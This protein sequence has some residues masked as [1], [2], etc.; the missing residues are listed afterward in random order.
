MTTT[1]ILGSIFL[2]ARTSS[3]PLMS[4]M[5]NSETTTAQCTSFKIFRPSRADTA[6]F[7][8]LLRLRPVMQLITL[9]NKFRRLQLVVQVQLL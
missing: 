4:G 5:R 3:E 9:H 6:T 2:M 8:L 1:L 7:T